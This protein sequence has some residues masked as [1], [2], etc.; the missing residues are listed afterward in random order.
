MTGEKGE[1][2]FRTIR[3]CFT[4]IVKK[5]NYDLAFTGNNVEEI[6]KDFQLFEDVLVNE[7]V[8][9]RGQLGL[10]IGKKYIIDE[11]VLE[12][13]AT[14]ELRLPLNNEQLKRVKILSKN[15]SLKNSKEPIKELSARTT[16]IVSKA[17]KRRANEGDFGDRVSEEEVKK[18]QKE[19]A[20]K[21]KPKSSIAEEI[22]KN[23]GTSTKLWFDRS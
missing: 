23:N 18:Y 22:E 4:P 9:R 17:I 14:I 20:E 15:L 10:N 12:P 2:G 19:L 16:E 6:K 21:N 11:V 8:F 5:Q 1:T 13:N 3:E 7:G